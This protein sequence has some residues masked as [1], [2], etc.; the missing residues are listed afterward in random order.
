MASRLS[1]RFHNVP[2]LSVLREAAE[3]RAARLSSRHPQILG[4]NVVFEK[5]HNR[6]RKGNGIKARVEVVVPG[7]TL[8][9]SK[10]A[11]GYGTTQDGLAALDAAFSAAEHAVKA[12]L[13]RRRR[14]D[15]RRFEIDQTIAA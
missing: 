9:L 3:A 8:V 2:N 7:K 6:R 4:F 11:D 5:P 13:E 1:V 12:R 14:H 10:H 15:S